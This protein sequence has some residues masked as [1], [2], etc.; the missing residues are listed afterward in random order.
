MVLRACLL[1]LNH[2]LFVPTWDFNYEAFRQAQ[3]SFEGY[4][5]YVS[6]CEL[7]GCIRETLHSCAVA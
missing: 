3:S 6:L 1:V 7:M 2:F 5:V 4:A